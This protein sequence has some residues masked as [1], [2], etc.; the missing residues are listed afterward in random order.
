MD[1]ATVRDSQCT[2]ERNE[3]NKKKYI[4]KMSNR[5][6]HMNNSLL[7]RKTNKTET[8]IKKCLTPYTSSTWN[9]N[10]CLF[11]SIANKMCQ[12]IYRACSAHTHTHY[13]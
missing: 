7:N 4:D 6:S 13:A 5:L 11:F 9:F 3:S 8:N 1:R 10:G 2:W 12:V